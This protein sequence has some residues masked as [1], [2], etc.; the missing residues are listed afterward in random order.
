VLENRLIEKLQKQTL[1]ENLTFI[2]IP[3]N[4]GCSC[5]KIF[6][7]LKA[8]NSHLT[9]DQAS[10]LPGFENRKYF[11]FFRKPIDRFVSVYRW[12][13]RAHKDTENIIHRLSMEEVI[14][15]LEDDK[16]MGTNKVDHLRF[17]SDSSK[18]DKMFRS[19]FFWI[20]EQTDVFR[21]ENFKQEV[22]RFAEKYNIETENL[23][24]EHAN[25]N[26]Q[27]GSKEQTKEELFNILSTSSRLKNKF[28]TFYKR[29]FDFYESEL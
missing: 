7:N 24:I 18:L 12:R 29:D 6:F 9:V 22:F 15:Y 17:E 14:D 13:K 28:Y 16:I 5:L 26:N 23:Y 4:Y 10:R 27:H 25:I 20:N 21:C 8:A 1:N 19:Q 3:K 11:C 2:H